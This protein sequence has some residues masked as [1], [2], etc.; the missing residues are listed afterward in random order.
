[1]SDDIMPFG[2]HK[3]QRIATIPRQYLVWLLDSGAARGGVKREVERVLGAKPTG[4]VQRAPG[5][6]YVTPTYRKVEG[7]EIPPWDD[8]WGQPENH[9]PSIDPP[10]DVIDELNE[11]FKAIVA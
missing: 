5:V 3:G 1:M 9:D 10:F 4:T 11:E 7:T 2:K 6:I 8:G